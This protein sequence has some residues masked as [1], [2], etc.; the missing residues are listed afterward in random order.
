MGQCKITEAYFMLTAK[1]LDEA[2]TISW[3]TGD[4]ATKV[5]WL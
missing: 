2:A 3:I 4:G 1:R 5:F